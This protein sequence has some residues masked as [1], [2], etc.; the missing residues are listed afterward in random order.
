MSTNPDHSSRKVSIVSGQNGY[1]NHAFETARNRKISAA[2]E[3]ADMG[4]VR[5]KSI[6]HNAQ[7]PDYG[8]PAGKTNGLAK[9]GS[10]ISALLSNKYVF[11]SVSLRNAVTTSF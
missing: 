9:D 11:F 4:P 8:F 7:P 1:D 3:H 5:K 2:S 10:L 6:L